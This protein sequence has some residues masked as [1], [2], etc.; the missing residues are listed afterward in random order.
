MIKIWE[1]YILRE[2]LKLFALFL[3]GFY[4]LYVV[5]DYSTHMQDFTLVKN[6]SILK[7]F[8]YYLLQFIKRMDILLPLA[9]LIGSIKV[10]CQ[11]NLNRELL[12]FQSAGIRMKKLMRPFFFVGFCLVLINLGVNEFIVPHSLN[13]IDKFHDAHLRHSFRGKRTDPLHVMHLDDHSKLVYQ[14]YDAAR[15]AFFDV[16]WIRSPSDLWRMRYLK[17]DPQHPQGQWV[18]HLEQ[19]ENGCFEKTQSF[20]SLIFRDLK[21]NRDMPRRGYI[22]FENRSLKELWK[23]LKTDSLLSSFETKEVLTQFLF[24]LIMPFLALL[25]LIAIIPFCTSY[26]KNLPQFYLYSVGIFTFV[27]FI[28]LMDAAVILGESDTLSPYVAILSPFVILLSIFGWRFAN[29]R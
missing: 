1:R 19:K 14:Y 15:E 25:V 29:T 20:S 3:F 10:L 27:A 11:L 23:I 18:D 8:Q 5:I 17:A 12:A 26:S 2:L 24:K 22:P 4:F 9:L 6:L 28:A 7:I 13:F 16:I 21:W